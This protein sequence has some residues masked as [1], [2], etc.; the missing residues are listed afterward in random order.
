[1]GLTV[2]PVCFDGPAENKATGR[3]SNLDIGIL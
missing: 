1:M 3:N 2:I